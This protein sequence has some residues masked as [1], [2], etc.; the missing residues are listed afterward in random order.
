MDSSQLFTAYMTIVRKEVSRF[1]RVWKQTI[2]PPVITTTLY[3]VIFGQ[4]IGSRIGEVGGFSYMEFIVPGLVMMSVIMNSFSHVVSSFYM[5]KF[6]KTIEEILVS[7]TPYWVI[8]FGFITGGVIRG[9]VTGGIVLAVALFFTHVSFAHIGLTLLFAFLTSLLFALVG[10]LNG[11]IADSFDS[12]SVVP[13]FV[14]TPLTYLG[15]VFYSISMLPPIW[16]TISHANPILY[17]IDGFRYGMHGTSDIAPW[18]SFVVL[19]GFCTVFFSIIWYMFSKGK[20][21]RT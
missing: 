7:P 14:L 21:I 3:Y 6:Q 1:L 5:A 4:F 2:V 9:M 18:I 12:T 20:G 19:V 8:I 16:Q 11:L 17:M 13:N 15:G 10:L